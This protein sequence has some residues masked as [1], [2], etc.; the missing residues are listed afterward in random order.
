MADIERNKRM[1][2]AFCEAFSR[3]DWDRLRSIC[4]ED[5]RWV[6]PMRKTMQSG[7]LRSN[8]AAM[9]MLTAH[10]RTLDETIEAFRITKATSRDNAFTLEITGMTAEGDRVAAE[11]QGHAVCE[12]TGRSY[13]NLYMYLISFRGGK[14]RELREY[15]D[16]L[17]AYDVWM[18]P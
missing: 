4:T 12:A 13:D 2:T 11:A 7:Q 6:V 17:H 10:D 5:F 15:Q 3:S 1:A 18:A 16:T 14:I 9:A 8:A